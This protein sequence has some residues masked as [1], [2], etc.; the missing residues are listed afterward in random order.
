MRNP[1]QKTAA[2]L[3]GAVAL[4]SGAYALGSQTDGS[5]EAAGDRAGT[6]YGPGHF[7]GGPPGAGLDR[8]ADRLGVDEADLREALEDVRGDLKGPGEVRSDFA[9]ELADELG[10]TEAKVEAALERIRKRHAEEHGERR[11]ALAEALAKRLNLD[12][13]KVKEALETPRFFG[14][15]GP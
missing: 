9:E 7:R 4:A 6:G 14:R 3:A 5:A 2:V 12:A 11:D 15:P 1:K 10:T 8:L 13:A